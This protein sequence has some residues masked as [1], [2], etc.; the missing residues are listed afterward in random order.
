MDNNSVEIKEIIHEQSPEIAQGV[1][2]E[3]V[4]EQGAGDQGLMFGYA[5]NE[6]ENLM[7][8]PITYSHRLVE[9][10]AFV[11][12]SGKLDWLRPD[13]KSQ[14]TIQFENGQ[15][16]FIDTVVLSTQHDDNVL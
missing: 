8:A 4:T 14:V 9:Q 2:S 15:P 11:R 5:T 6:T 3:D 10:Q 12:K 13:A 7:P 16:D 1:D